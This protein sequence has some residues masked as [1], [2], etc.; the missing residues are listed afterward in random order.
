METAIPKHLVC[1]RS[2][3]RR[4]DD[5]FVP[6][7]P[8]WTA[9]GDEAMSAVVMGYFGV[10]WRGEAMRQRALVGLQ[11]IDNSLQGPN[12]PDHRDYAHYVDQAG[13]DNL[14]AIGYWLKPEAYETWSNSAEVA[15]WWRDDTKCSG[16]LG[17]FREILLPTSDRFETLF[18]SP[19]EM[20]GVGI[21][22]GGRSIDD[23]QEHSYWGSMRDRLPVS[24]TDKL[25][26]RGYL[27]ASEAAGSARRIG[28]AGH[29]NV[30]II[31][32]GQDWTDT[33]GHERDLY[34]NSIEPIFST[35]MDFLRDGGQPIG[36]YTNRYMM[37]VDVSGNPIEKSF[38]LSHWRSLGEMEAWAEHHPTHIAIFG[39]FMQTV[40]ELEFNLDLRLYHEVTVVGASQQF[41][42]YINCHAATGLLNAAAS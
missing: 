1:P 23:I 22:M 20:E 28:V 36:C 33:K 12:G 13:Y 26:P 38:G 15:D 18:S 4:I 14:I 27:V 39:S 31:R 30:A 41:Y 34:L 10:Q 2:N 16:D 19:D 6:P 7:Y 29:D 40:Q 32:L 35:G 37:C 42:E 25:E 5:D 17:F 24:Q 8:A 11:E 3:Q 9:R 21:A